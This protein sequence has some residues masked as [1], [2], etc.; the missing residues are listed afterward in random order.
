[1]V[2]ETLL[3]RHRIF[4]QRGLFALDQAYMNALV[5]L[6]PNHSESCANN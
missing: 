3:T 2:S 4:I 6:I 5:S 1:L